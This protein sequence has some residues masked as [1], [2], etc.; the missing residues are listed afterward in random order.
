MT[1]DNYEQMLEQDIDT[2]IRAPILKQRNVQAYDILLRLLS[3]SDRDGNTGRLLLTC[4]AMKDLMRE[5][6]CSRLDKMKI[7]YAWAQL[8]TRDIERIEKQTDDSK[9]ITETKNRFGERA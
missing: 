5:Y 8:R 4:Q 9:K 1:K 6:R 3:I 7:M 2:E